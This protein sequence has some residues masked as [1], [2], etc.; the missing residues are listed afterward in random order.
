MIHLHY[1]NRL[2][3]LIDPLAQL[4][5][6]DQ[7]RDP[8]D[9]VTVVVPGRAIEEF[10]KLR[11]AEQEGIAANIEFPFLRGYLARI[12]ERAG[13]GAVRVLDTDGLQIAIFE[14]LRSAAAAS[15]AELAPVR[16]Y[17]GAARDDERHRSLRLFEL[18]ARVARLLREYS[19]AR[20]AMLNE[21]PRHCTLEDD[22][23]GESERWQRRIYLALF[24][25]DGSLRR[26]WL[27][28]GGEG[29][30]RWMMLPFAYDEIGGA[31]L[32]A[33]LPARL[34]LFGIG[35]AGPEYIRIFARLGELIDLHVYTLNPCR[36]F[37]DDVPDRRAAR[38]ER[39]GE[40][41]ESSEDPFGLGGGDNLALRYWGR[42]GRE[43]IRLLNETTECD[44]DGHFIEPMGPGGRAT[45]LGRVQQAILERRTEAGSP[46]DVR[47]V[48][49]N[50]TPENDGSI[51]ILDCPGVRREIE[52]VADAIWSLIRSASGKSGPP[53]RF[54][55]IAVVIPDAQRDRYLPHLEGVFAR[56]HE[57]PL[58]LVDRR[59][60]AQSR[61]AEAVELLLR[62]PRGRF[63]RDEMVRLLTHPALAGHEADGLAGEWPVW[64]RRLGVQFGADESDL[65]DTYI[66]PPLFH[67]DYALKQM[68]LGLLMAGAPSGESRTFAVA[69]GREYLP[70]EIAEDAAESAAIMIR[71]T[72]ALIREAQEL[73]G[74]MLTLADW[75]RAL[76]E[77]I[78][79]Y[80]QPAD[81]RDERVLEMVLRALESL[82]CD[83]LV[84]EPVP[85]EIALELALA[86]LAEGESEQ[87]TYAES[88]VVAG[89]LGVLRTIPFRAV[90][91]VG[92]NEAD[93]PAREVRDLLDLR[94]ARRRAGDVSPAERDRYLFLETLLAARDRICLSYVGRDGPT[95]EKR[96]PSAVVRD[97]QAIVAGMIGAQAA[98]RLEMVHP[99]SA[100]DRSYWPDLA[101]GGAPRRAELV[102][103][104]REARRA[105][106]F[107]ALRDDLERHC[108]GASDA[109]R[110]ETLLARLNAGVREKLMPRLR[111]AG[112]AASGAGAPGEDAGRMQLSIA[113]LRRYLECP[114]QGAARYA[115]GMREEDDGGDPES[116]DEPLEQSPLETA[117][118]LRDVLARA[119][120]RREEIAAR[121]DEAYRHRMLMSA[122][123]VGPFA[124]RLRRKH[125]ALLETGL[126]QVAAA[127][128]AN[129]AQWQR[130]AIGGA[131]EFATIDRTLDPIVLEV[132]FE[133]PDGR[134]ITAIELRGVIGPIAPALDRSIKLITRAEARTADFLEAALG[135]IVLAA[136]GVKMPPEFVAMA[137]GGKSDAGSPA[138]YSRVL[139][140]PEPAAARAY[141]AQLAADL[142]G[143]NDYFLPL[144]AV[145]RI[146]T[147]RDRSEESIEEA[148]GRIRENS[149]AHCRS[150]FGPVR[151]ARDFRTP[152][153][154]IVSG[155]IARRYGPLMQIFARGKGGRGRGGT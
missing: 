12:A 100:H 104:N 54:H 27:E 141:L 32:R 83:G 115:L 120:G 140:P 20:R 79:T 49:G 149:D 142:C 131:E 107:A 55:Q 150:D 99:L 9:R 36:E 153:K 26:E 90:F 7:T 105:A 25:R 10:L 154:E 35:Y 65:A 134:E 109:G 89:S 28:G 5:S 18:S 112:R 133:R 88:G 80:V 128:V 129:L 147:R 148:V 139:S 17:L 67:W 41:L 146:V 68:A 116:G 38:P 84:N 75:R 82:H 37:W 78:S 64:C 125:L 19:T 87:G 50:V 16:A 110:D 127:G 29:G 46:E 74:S 39:A 8:L 59:L 130:I 117:I 136:A 94:Q 123:P 143:I 14:F 48:N 91:M 73:A 24:E 71:R 22:R 44:F 76:I 31:A 85:Y 47:G 114:L 40:L 23:M 152:V 151:H 97:L 111:L 45:L 61:L 135:A 113:A 132:C 108:G 57:I 95:G 21:W 96:E 118:M 33:V 51:Q 138:K 60:G 62:L 63:S 56:A 155:L 2:E 101:P 42:A 30:A 66:D 81:R 52:I 144:E 102:S 34:H 124:E 121:Y 70:F 13:G 98:A 1:S 43:Y 15:D 86:R 126:A 6:A 93:F 77:L 119:R 53:L 137:I 11:L 92:L 72:R 69:G 58:N 145:E 103:F 4:V 106:Q 122:A 3:E